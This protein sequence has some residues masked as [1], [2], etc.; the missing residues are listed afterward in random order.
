M[1][2]SV[3]EI[4]ALVACQHWGKHGRAGDLLRWEACCPSL[5]T[6]RY[7]MSMRVQWW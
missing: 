6:H 2:T 1:N 3:S 7:S 4:S 5:P